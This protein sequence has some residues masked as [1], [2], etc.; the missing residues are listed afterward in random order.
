MN[1]TTVQSH[2]E[3]GWPSIDWA[4]ATHVVQ[5]LQQRIFRASQQGNW[6]QVRSLQKLLLMKPIEPMLRVRAEVAL[7]LT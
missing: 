7:Q 5:R 3:A 2:E 4:A 1:A 6:R